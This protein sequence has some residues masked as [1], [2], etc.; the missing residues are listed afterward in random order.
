MKIV[1]SILTIMAGLVCMLA[2]ADKNNGDPV[3]IVTDSSDEASYAAATA[4]YRDVDGK[5][6]VIA[7]KNG[8]SPAD[9][10][11]LRE[12]WM[13]YHE[14]GDMQY[15]NLFRYGVTGNE[16]DG[17]EIHSK[18]MGN[19]PVVVKLWDDKYSSKVSTEENSYNE[20]GEVHEYSK[21]TDPEMFVY[22]PD[23]D[24][25]TG[26]S[27][28]VCPGGAMVVLAWEDELMPMVRDFVS[29]GIAVVGV[30][31]RLNTERP[32]LPG[33]RRMPTIADYDP[34]EIMEMLPDPTAPYQQN[35][36]EDLAQARRL[37]IENAGQWNL[38]PSKIGYLGFS[39]GGGALSYNLYNA[40]AKD[41]P[42]FLCSIY[43]PVYQ[44]S[45][46]EHAPKSFIAVH[47]DHRDVAAKC[48]GM[49]RAWK[50]AGKDA[51]LHVYSENT[52]GLFG[53]RRS[54]DEDLNTPDGCWREQLY[55]WLVA[56]GLCK[57]KQPKS[58]DWRE[59]Y[60]S[61]V[62]LKGKEN[63]S[64]VLCIVEKDSPA[65]GL[66]TEAYKFKVDSPVVVAC[67]ENGADIGA[68]EQAWREFE[69]SG[70]KKNEDLFRY[71][72]VSDRF[73]GWEIHSKN[74]AEEIVVPLLDKEVPVT[75]EY[76][77]LTKYGEKHLYHF[78]QNPSLTIRLPD[79]DKATGTAVVIYPGGGMVSLA[80]EEE[81]RTAADFLNN[82]GIAAIGVKYRTKTEENR[83]NGSG[84]PPGMSTPVQDFWKLEEP[85][86]P[87][88]KELEVS[89]TYL[90]AI[91]DANN[92][93]L[94]IK[95]N[96]AQWGI[97]PEKIGVMGFSAGGIVMCKTYE[98]RPETFK[99]AFICSVYGPCGVH[100]PVPAD[101]PK[102]FTADHADH[103]GMAARCLQMALKWKKAG[104]DMEIHLYG[105][106]TGGLF[107]GGPMKD[108]N[109]AKGD[110][111]VCFHSWLVAN[112][113][114]E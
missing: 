72:Q 82:K 4:Q 7:V 97:D 2:Y 33:G 8:D 57:I 61:P 38:D 39:A 59:A 23:P 90:S 30:K 73:R 70:W 86:H 40:D 108:K 77:D 22:L 42:A 98:E 76:V 85:G 62:V 88:G 80:W 93:F 56:N 68:M 66:I 110:W 104:K 65:E 78:I 29:K 3:F 79:K 10:T 75:A 53:V 100:F 32:R 103:P 21:V 20:F 64:P 89:G 58:N 6:A 19:E 83:S 14:K 26:T 31:Y 9:E 43:A 46:P 92:A 91:E 49:F 113:F 114:T 17:W 41:M 101:A 67:C 81:F 45:V 16:F 63:G 34:N 55:S 107:A 15:E 28:L 102:L 105:E 12:A 87:A 112:G 18:N 71:R 95:E 25:A 36:G 74:F 96:A 52:G 84:R 35:A 13:L 69:E 99:P 106:N 47:A 27:I 5:P 44:G 94:Y 54:G 24:K 1:K 60:N 50:E 109:T 11:A 51:E 111:K 48:L 37:L